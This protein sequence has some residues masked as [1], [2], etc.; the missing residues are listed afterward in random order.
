M[1]SRA[2]LNSTKAIGAQEALAL[3]GDVGPAPFKQVDDGGPAVLDVGVV[4]GEAEPEQRHQDE[5]PHA[6]AGQERESH[7]RLMLPPR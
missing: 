6:F 2:Y 5:Q 4:L 1:F 7:T 3:R